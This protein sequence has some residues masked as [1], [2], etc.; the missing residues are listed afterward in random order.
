MMA[1]AANILHKGSRLHYLVSGEGK[2]LLFVFHGFGQSAELMQA[3]LKPLESKYTLVLVDL[4]FHGESVLDEH[5]RPLQPST[6]AAILKELLAQFPGQNPSI[7]AFSSGCKFALSAWE[8][9]PGCWQELILLAPDGIIKNPWYAFATANPLT[10]S[11][12]RFLSKNPSWLFV[13][14]KISGRLGLVK[15]SILKFVGSQLN[16]QAKREMAFQVWVNFRLLG[17][18][19]ERWE[20][21]LRA[22]NTK[23]LVCVAKF[24]RIIVARDI[25][26]KLAKVTGVHVKEFQTGHNGLVVKW[27]ENALRN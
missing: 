8:L 11:L 16:T 5:H 27:V 24:D 4:F 1:R 18:P 9:M 7:L 10:R 20:K 17:L 6:W 26:K 13:L 15:S 22:G 19:K 25:R 2:S 3:Q 21:C 12:F 14:I 23:V